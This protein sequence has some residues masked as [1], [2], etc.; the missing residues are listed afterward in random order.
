MSVKVLPGI[1]TDTEAKRS[2]IY[3]NCI[4]YGIMIVGGAEA[5]Q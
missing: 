4:W 5:T 3:L 2:R 1:C